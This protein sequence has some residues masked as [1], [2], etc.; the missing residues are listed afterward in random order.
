MKSKNK[1]VYHGAFQEG[2]T[3][4]QKLEGPYGQGAV[5]YPNGD[6]FEGFFH[7]SYAHIDGPAYAA[8]GSEVES[9]MV[10]GRFLMKDREF[11]TID[12]ERVVFEVDR[13]CKRLGL[14]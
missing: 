8:N 5:D 10:E 2:D 11:L 6:H 1:I 12:R 14:I 7:L 9:V 4:L 13:T 3:I